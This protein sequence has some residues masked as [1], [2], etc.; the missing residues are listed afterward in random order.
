ML[1]SKPWDKNLKSASKRNSNSNVDLLDEI[2]MLYTRL[3]WE[4]CFK[5]SLGP[6]KHQK[7]ESKDSVAE[8][9]SLSCRLNGQESIDTIEKLGTEFLIDDMFYQ[10]KYIFTTCIKD[11]PENP[12]YRFL[13]GNCL[14]NLGSYEKAIDSY[15]TAL[16]IDTSH[17]SARKMRAYCYDIIGDGDKALEDYIVELELNKQD[18]W[19]I[20]RISDI[21]I[22]NRKLIE[23]MTQLQI[24][25]CIDRF[26]SSSKQI[27]LVVKKLHELVAEN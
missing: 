24:A 4:G 2:N 7:T 26:N 18:L 8:A 13:L 19:L 21:H 14:F 9:R 6:L 27:M 20:K 15:S 3:P 22:I 25:I 11:N 23:A 12:E 10:A 17:C 1:Q 5:R 16:S